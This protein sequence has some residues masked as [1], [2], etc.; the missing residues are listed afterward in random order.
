MAKLQYSTEDEKSLNS[1]KQAALFPYKI[2]R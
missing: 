2:A 1:Y